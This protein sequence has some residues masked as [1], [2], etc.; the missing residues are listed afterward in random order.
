MGCEKEGAFS[1]FHIDIYS[2]DC[3]N[4]NYMLDCVCESNIYLLSGDIVNEVILCD[5]FH[6]YLFAYNDAHSYGR[7]IY[8][9]MRV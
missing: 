3:P 8:H 5:T 6:Y 9:V 7:S 1:F 2:L 4:L